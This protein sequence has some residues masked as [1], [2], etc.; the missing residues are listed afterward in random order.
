MKKAGKKNNVIQ[1]KKEVEEWKGKYLRALADY[2]NLEK[3][4]AEQRTEEAKFVAKGLILKIL[5]I[6]DLLKRVEK[7][8]KDQGLQIAIKEFEVVLKEEKVEKIEA[9]G[10]KFDPNMMECVE[11]VNGKKDNEVIEEVVTGYMMYG[12]VIRVAKVKVGKE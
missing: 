3:R 10:K 8:L 2:Q 9:V 5:P 4:V 12:K 1:V 6:F 11:V 7:E